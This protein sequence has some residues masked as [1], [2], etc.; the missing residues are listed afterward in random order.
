MYNQVSAGCRASI[1]HIIEVFS[2]SSFLLYAL[3][4]TLKIHVRQSICWRLGVVGD[5][6]QLSSRFFK[7]DCLALSSFYASFDLPD[8]RWCA[9]LGFVPAG[10]V[11]I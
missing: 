7:V 1:R 9:V 8:G 5:D 11:S 2:F 10:S 3:L 4:R 6:V